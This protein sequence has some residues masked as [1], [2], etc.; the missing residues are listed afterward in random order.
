MK[1]PRA[2]APLLPTIVCAWCK[3]VVR[4]G[5]LKISHGI[6]RPCRA[7]FFGKRAAAAASILGLLRKP[8]TA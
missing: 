7:H 4:K 3:G 6:C 1:T 2:T 8:R 5:N